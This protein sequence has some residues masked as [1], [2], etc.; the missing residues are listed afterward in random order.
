M[1]KLSILLS[2]AIPFFILSCGGGSSNEEGNTKEEEV[3]VEK[4]TTSL[5]DKDNMMN[6]LEELNISIPNEMTFVE[7]KK[8]YGGGYSVQ[9]IS[10]GISEETRT[11]LDDWYKEQ[12]ENLVNDGWMKRNIRDNEEMM[13]IV[14]NQDIFI[15]SSDGIDIS[16]SF[17]TEKNSYSVFV[18][19]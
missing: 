1:K 11:M 2:L 10:E 8:A 18:K 19:P 4:K 13:G 15:K 3:K 17:D 7:I 16:T 5:S 6:R 14:A 9:F 12:C